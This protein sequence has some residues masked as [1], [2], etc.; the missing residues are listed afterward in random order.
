MEALLQPI[1]SHL[2]WIKPAVLQS[3]FESGNNVA[4]GGMLKMSRML[5]GSVKEKHFRLG[6]KVVEMLLCLKVATWEKKEQPH[7]FSL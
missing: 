4:G 5:F 2:N 7:H 6:L 1:L 3:G